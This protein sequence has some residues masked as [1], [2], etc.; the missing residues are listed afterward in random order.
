[1]QQETIQIEK[2]GRSLI[3][4]E[5]YEYFDQ[6]Y[7]D[8]NGF[9]PLKFGYSNYV[10]IVGYNLDSTGV[11]KWYEDK[12]LFPEGTTN[13]LLF[14]LYDAA[15]NDLEEFEVLEKSFIVAPS[16]RIRLNRDLFNLLIPE[17]FLLELKKILAYGLDRRYELREDNLQFVRGKI[18]IKK[19][20]R[21][22]INH[23]PHISCIYWDFTTNIFINQALL[24]AS[25]LLSRNY[26]V[27]YTVRSSLVNFVLMMR[28]EFVE[29][30][31]ITTHDFNKSY[32][33]PKRYEL[34][35]EL[36]KAIISSI[37]HGIEVKKE[38]DCPSFLIN[39][40][41]VWE[42]FLRSC[43]RKS[44]SDWKVEKIKQKHSCLKPAL[45]ITP[46]LLASKD[47][48]LLIID[49]KYKSGRVRAPDIYQMCSYI[50]HFKDSNPTSFLLYLD[51]DDNVESRSHETYSFFI[52][53]KK[54]DIHILYL[55][56]LLDEAADMDNFFELFA[57]KLKENIENLI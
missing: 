16:I 43:I 44:F 23:N 24:F 4:M 30:V 40:P 2:P 15:I 45:G 57:L 47:D 53:E 37:Y 20:L 51:R 35:L 11:F 42:S 5:L 19:Q 48:K 10:G 3:P 25:D 55:S 38:V 33:C 50:A 28:Q 39:V 21:N 22:E 7:R 1:M 9:Y 27:S 8:E 13:P 32:Y 56:N 52:E 41:I 31:F 18:N 36:A 14:K 34:A 49:A 29:D 12:K 17:L 46:D 26:R 54:F 6:K